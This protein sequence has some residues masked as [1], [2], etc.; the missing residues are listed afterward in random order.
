MPEEGGINWAAIKTESYRQGE[1]RMKKIRGLGVAISVCILAG[2]AS[3]G[4][5]LPDWVPTLAAAQ[6]E[7]APE[8]PAKLRN[9]SNSEVKISDNEGEA[10]L[11]TVAFRPGTSSATV[12]RLAKRFGCNG[13]TGAGLIT[14]KGPVEVY[15]MKC[16]NGT[17]FMAQCELRQCRPMR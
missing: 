10:T 7:P 11:Q 4:F 13:S 1:S 2:C 5:K 12:E 16:D 9:G 15:R 8:Q 14:D 6:P 17:I 3:T